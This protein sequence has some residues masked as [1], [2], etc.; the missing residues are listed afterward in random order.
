[1][2][3]LKKTDLNNV[4]EDFPSFTKALTGL[5]ITPISTLDKEFSLKY[6]AEQ[7]VNTKAEVFY[8]NFVAPSNA[9]T[10][11]T[12]ADTFS[13]TLVRD[14]LK[15]FVIN[16]LGIAPNVKAYIDYDKVLTTLLE[17]EELT[18]MV[19][20]ENDT[21]SLILY[22]LPHITVDKKQIQALHV[23]V[24]ENDYS[25]IDKET[26]NELLHDIVKEYESIRPKIEKDINLLSISKSYDQKQALVSQ[27]SRDRVLLLQQLVDLKGKLG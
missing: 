11:F 18:P 7:G 27:D 10:M 22:S 2:T 8:N 6:F 25:D 17:K 20:E 26:Y 23:K 5:N 16:L 1:M 9:H 14:R 13:T 3:K 24:L 21:K 15:T 19:V 12:L 4:K